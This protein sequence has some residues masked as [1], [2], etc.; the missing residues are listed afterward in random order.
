MRKKVT[1]KQYRAYRI[2]LKSTPYLEDLC[3]RAKNLFNAAT[4]LVRQELFTTGNWLQ[5]IALYQQLKAKPVYLALKELTDS[6]IPQQV[7]RQVEQVWGSYF[8]ALKA[9]HQGSS[10]FQGR[11]RLPKYLPKDGRRLISFPR[12][13]VRGVSIL[14]PNNMLQRGFPT[15]LLRKFPF[16]PSTVLSARLVPFYDRFVLEL[17]Y[18]VPPACLDPLSKRIIGLDLGVNNLVAM[19]DGLLI[20]GGLLRPSINGIIS[21]WLN[22]GRWRSN[23][24]TPPVLTAS[25]ACSGSKRIN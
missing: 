23:T 2:Q 24:T 16:T 15:I 25:F 22:I 7:L 9:Y 13:R 1:H 5:Y 4:Y 6:Y 19:S 18:E 10:S 8:K 3:I 20:R 17:I 14:F 11:P 21:S 12:D